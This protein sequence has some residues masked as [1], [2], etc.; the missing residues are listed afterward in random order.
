MNIKVNPVDLKGIFHSNLFSISIH[1][2]MLSH[3]LLFRT[4]TCFCVWK[5]MF[6]YCLC[7][8]CNVLM[9]LLNNIFDCCLMEDEVCFGRVKF[10]KIKLKWKWKLSLKWTWI[11]PDFYFGF[12]ASMQFNARGGKCRFENNISFRL[13]KRWHKLIHSSNFRHISLKQDYLSY[14]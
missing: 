8:D 11:K 13:F 6:S 12:S 4:V 9:I 3:G 5:C 14:F 1:V 10:K 7:W 2:M